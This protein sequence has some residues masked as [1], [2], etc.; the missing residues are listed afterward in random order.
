MPLRKALQLLQ[1]GGH[2]EQ[3]HY[4]ANR[5]HL[6]LLIEYYRHTLQK[7]RARAETILAELKELW[8]RYGKEE[9]LSQNRELD[10]YR[11]GLLAGN[12]WDLDSAIL[13]FTRAVE[14]D[15]VYQQAY[16]Y[17]AL[18]KGKKQDAVGAIQDATRALE[19]NAEARESLAKQK[20]RDYIGQWKDASMERNL[21]DLQALA[22]QVRGSKFLMLGKVEE[23]LKDGQALIELQAENSKGY[24]IVGFAMLASGEVDAARKKL[25]AA[26]ELE[27]EPQLRKV[28]EDTLTNINKAP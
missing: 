22:L 23:A 26:L 1:A 16:V 7:D 11:L 21:G 13:F 6:A 12:A 15:P 9:I 10:Y 20:K 14:K 5:L 8:H 17:R 28:L 18:A 19:L 3:E 27:T 2:R 4:S 25:N 24:T